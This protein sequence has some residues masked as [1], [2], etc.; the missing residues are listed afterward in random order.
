VN[1][2]TQA[3]ERACSPDVTHS[4]SRCLACPVAL[5][6]G[7][8]VIQASLVEVRQAQDA[9]SAETTSPARP[10]PALQFE[11]DGE[12]AYRHVPPACVTV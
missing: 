11:E 3:V 1:G 12:T 5:A 10:P 7:S 9:G 2:R 6:P 8:I 4:G